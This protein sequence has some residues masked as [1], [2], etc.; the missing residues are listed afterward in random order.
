MAD[1]PRPSR[2]FFDLWARVYDAPPVQRAI[3]LP[4]Q[5][6]VFATLRLASP[7]HVLDIGCGTGILTARMAGELPDAQVVGCDFSMGMLEQAADRS[8]HPAWVQGDA[9]HLPLRD[10][11]VDAATSTESFHWFPDPDGALTELARVIR[12]GGLLL[13]AMVHPRSRLATR[14]V[15]TSSRLLGQPGRWSTKDEMEAR[16][17][18]AGFEVVS[19]NRV[20]RIGAAAVPTVLT[21]ARRQDG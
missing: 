17:A 11:S 13:V 9:L 21:V 4:V 5:D 16:V 18:G 14:W 2:L 7:R 20:S 10:G 6:A 1:E 19:Q 8:A 3:Y 12:P 15:T